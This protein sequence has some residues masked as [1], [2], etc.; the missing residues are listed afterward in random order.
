MKEEKVL[1]NGLK[2]NYKIAGEGPAILVLHGW[3]GSSDSWI[4]V[5]NVLAQKGYKVICPDLPGFG[6]SVTPPSAWSLDDYL[7]WLVSF[8]NYQKLNNFF[9]LAHSFGGRITVKFATVYPERVKKIILCASS[10]VKPKPGLKTRIIFLI[11]KIGNMLFSPKPLLRFKDGARNIFYVFLRNRDYVKANGTM[12]E[13]IKKVLTEDLFPELDKIENKTL[14]IW[15]EKD[16]IVPLSYGYIFNKRIKNSELKVLPKVGHS[17]H[18]EV[19]EK[20]AE[21]SLNFYKN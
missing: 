18:L 10:G 8:I 4:K 13:T 12:K 14:L 21:I 2:I 16:K 11:S 7:K 20:L 5:I 6:K 17:P 1:I 15:G 9:I 19:P 3:G